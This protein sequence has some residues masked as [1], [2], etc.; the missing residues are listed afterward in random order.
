MPSRVGLALLSSSDVRCLFPLLVLTF[1]QAG[2]LG[3][4]LSMT[5]A[6]LTI[7]GSIP[8]FRYNP[9]AFLFFFPAT[10]AVGSALMFD[11]FPSTF[12]HNDPVCY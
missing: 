12:G 10:A 9:F 6:R 7:E 5:V 3:P 2:G 11:C 1:N 4:S 8:G